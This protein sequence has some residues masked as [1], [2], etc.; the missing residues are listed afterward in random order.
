MTETP[1]AELFARDPL[2]LSSQDIDSIVNH[3]RSQRHRFI[4]GDMKAGTTKPRAVSKTTAKEG[5]ALKAAGD[6]NL[7]DLGL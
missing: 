1:I 7:D 3:L 2:N 4:Q 5:E 6:F